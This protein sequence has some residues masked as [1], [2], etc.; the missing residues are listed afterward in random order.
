METE[1]RAEEGEERL[2]G[3]ERN[4]GGGGGGGGPR[5]GVEGKDEGNSKGK[6]EKWGGARP[7]WAD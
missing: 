3:A 2:K 6:D 7:V 5:A 1:R 4:G